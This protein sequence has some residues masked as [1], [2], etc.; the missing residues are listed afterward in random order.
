LT[1]VRIVGS[2]DVWWGEGIA[3]YPDGSTWHAASIL[4]LRNGKVFRET[5]YWA[6]PFDPPAWRAQWV[7]SIKPA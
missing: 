5:A 1:V 3:R 4:E 7:E 6:P 2:G